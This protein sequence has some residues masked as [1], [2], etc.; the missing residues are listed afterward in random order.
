MWPHRR[1]PTSVRWVHLCGSLNILWHCLFG[2]GMKTELF[3][4]CGPCW[5][6]LTCWHIECSTFIASSFRVWNSSTGIPSPPLALFVVM[7]PKAH[8]MSHS[9]MS[10]SRWVI[11]LSWLSGS[12]RSFLYI[13]SVYSCHLFLISSASVRSLPFLSFIKSIFAWN[14]PFSQSV[15]QSVFLK[16]SLVFPILLFSSVSLHWSLRKAFLSLLALLWNSAFRWVYLPFSPLP[17]ASLLFSVICKASSD[18]YFA[19][20]HFFFLGDSLDHCLL[21]N[22]INLCP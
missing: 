15:S 7:L 14:V 11:T 8:L 22:V 5:V 2:L 17:F 21:Y 10:G 12:W 9:R 16:R 1:Q 4:S 18:S 13:S 19:F 6:F 20:L 3:Q